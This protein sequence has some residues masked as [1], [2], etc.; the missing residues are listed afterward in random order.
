MML[1]ALVTDLLAKAGRRTLGCL[2]LD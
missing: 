1:A 2:A